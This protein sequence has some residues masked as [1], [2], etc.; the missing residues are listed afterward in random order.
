MNEG[1]KW[2]EMFE[3]ANVV[4]FCVS[5]TDYDTLAINGNGCDIPIQNKM[6]QCKQLFERTVR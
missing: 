2:M 4:I 3:D 1:S 6:L 5:L